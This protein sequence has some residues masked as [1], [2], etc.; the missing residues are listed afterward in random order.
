MSEMTATAAIGGSARGPRG[1]DRAGAY[2]FLALGLVYVMIAAQSAR[3]LVLLA[4]SPA[5][6]AATASRTCTAAFYLITCHL[7]LVRPP[8]LARKGD[9]APVL[10]AFVATYGVWFVAFLPAAPAS[11]VRDLIGA[12]VTL[13]GEALMVVVILRLGRAFSIVPQAS[14]LVTAGPYRYV[15]HPL[16]LT[17]GIAILG[18][19]ISRLWW[20]AALF[21]AAHLALQIRRMMYEE[22]LLKSVFVDYEDYARRT[23]RLIPGVW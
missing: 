3:D 2:W 10:T 13:V 1:W 15:R 7:L 17:E 18:I 11:P 21:G 12:G 16:Y 5:S 20:A 6:I 23:A 8:P 9:A 4:A 19:L 14:A 22:R